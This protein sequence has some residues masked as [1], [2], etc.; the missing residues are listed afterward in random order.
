MEAEYMAAAA[1]AKEA[2]KKVTNVSNAW[3]SISA[4]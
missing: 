3:S 4:P 1:A 2:R